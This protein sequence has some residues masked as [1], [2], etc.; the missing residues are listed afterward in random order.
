MPRIWRSSRPWCRT[1]SFRSPRCAGDRKRRRFALLL[2]RFRWED[3]EAAERAGRRYER[4]QSVL[5]VDDVLSVQTL[6]HRPRRPRYWCCRCCRS[7]WEPGEDGTGRLT[8]TLAGDG[9]I[10][11]EVE[12]LEVTL[13]T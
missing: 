11:L 7:T 12:A 8:L 9:A 3:R 10:A 5:V 1:P 4:V 2:N 13:E 6:G